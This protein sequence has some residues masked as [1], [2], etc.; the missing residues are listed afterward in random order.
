MAGRV[1]ARPGFFPSKP[2]IFSFR[3]TFRRTP[4]GQQPYHATACWI[5]ANCGGFPASAFA[6]PGRIGDYSPERGRKS[7][8]EAGSAAFWRLLLQSLRD[9]PPQE[10]H[11]QPE[12]Q[13]GARDRFRE[14]RR[15]LS[16]VER[17]DRA[18]HARE[19]EGE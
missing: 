18:C 7:R 9:G 8:S 17:V 3:V 11:A 15:I 6:R 4:V 14:E 19:I 13:R 2:S 10:D 1:P 16:G 12:K 5:P